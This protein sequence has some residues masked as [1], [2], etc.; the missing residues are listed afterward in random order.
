[1]KKILYIFITMCTLFII[2]NVYAE[3]INVKLKT[4]IDGDTAIFLYNNEKIKA[5]FL[6]IDTPETEYSEKG[7]MPLGKEASEYTCNKLKNAQKIKLEYDNNS[8]KT[9]KYDRHLVWVWLDDKLL[10]KELV[11]IGYAKVSYLY[12]NYKYTNELI[13]EEETAKKK[14]IGIWNTNNT[15]NNNSNINTKSNNNNNNNS[16]I[17]LPIP[18]LIIIIVIIL[19]LK[20]KH[21]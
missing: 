12:N 18:I 16:N 20:K 13:S 3:K 19:L 4:C 17:N 15:S 10:Q 11:S 8:D 5:R 2:D 21:N 14:K 1:M 9:D 6:A 7:E